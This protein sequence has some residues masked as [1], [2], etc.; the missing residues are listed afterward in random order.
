MSAATGTPTMDR[1]WV[2]QCALSRICGVCARPLGRPI[3]FV[4]TDEEIGRN[5]FHLAPMHVACA[6]T[7]V[8]ATTRV[9]TTAGFEFVR[10]AKEDVD[11]RPRF[12]PNSLL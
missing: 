12:E 5:A 3:A 8:D 1:K 11:R 9:V 7:V 10:P 2:T 6:S 4:G